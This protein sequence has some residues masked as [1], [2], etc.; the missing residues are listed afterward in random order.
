MCL[1]FVVHMDVVTD[2]NMNFEDLR[3]Q[4]PPKSDSLFIQQLLKWFIYICLQQKLLAKKRLI[5]HVEQGFS[6]FIY[7]SWAYYNKLMIFLSFVTWQSF[8]QYVAW[9]AHMPQNRPPGPHRGG[10]PTDPK[11]FLGSL[12][13][14]NRQKIGLITTFETL[15]LKKIRKSF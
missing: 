8:Q 6:F 1:I 3:Q 11:F 9:G 12:G 14:P 10:W 5:W 7:K 4:L 15:L 2:S 13:G